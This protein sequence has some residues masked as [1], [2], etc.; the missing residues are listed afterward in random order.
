[1]LDRSTIDPCRKLVNA[2]RL[3]AIAAVLLAGCASPSPQ[4]CMLWGGC[5]SQ[6]LRAE[7]IRQ[8]PSPLRCACYSGP[9]Q[10]ATPPLHISAVLPGVAVAPTITERHREAVQQNARQ[11]VDLYKTD[12]PA[13]VVARLRNAGIEAHDCTA[14]GRR[15]GATITASIGR[16]TADTGGLG[17]RTQLEIHVVLTEAESRHVVWRASFL[18]GNRSAMGHK[19]DRENVDAFAENLVAELIRSGWLSQK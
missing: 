5:A 8:A 14:Q 15:D 13:S 12:A 11:I 1:M 3:M 19:P 4:A 18:T 16:I 17:W 7:T 2:S 9:Q 10:P 6:T